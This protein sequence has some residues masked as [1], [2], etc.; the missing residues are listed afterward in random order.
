MYRFVRTSM[1]KTAASQRAAVQWAA[2]VAG[3]LKKA[4]AVDLKYG[5]ELFG[6]GNVHWHLET[7]SVDKITALNAKLM[8]DRAYSELLEKG[9]A[10]W[11]EGS[12]KDTL[13]FLVE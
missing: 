11:V 1:P 13:V 10:L 4:Y 3:Y 5:V 8:Q 6:P 7:D 2:E 9:K 12:M